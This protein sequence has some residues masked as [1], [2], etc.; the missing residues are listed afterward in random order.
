[1]TICVE[2]IDEM[3][4]DNGKMSPE[5]MVMLRELLLRFCGRVCLEKEVGFC[6][7]KCLTSSLK[8]RIDKALGR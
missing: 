5:D 6:T 4:E 1:V 8:K 7:E 3:I 2:A